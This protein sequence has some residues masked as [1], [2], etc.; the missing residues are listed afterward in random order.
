[1]D[2]VRGYAMVIFIG[3]TLAAIGI[4]I[5]SAARRTITATLLTYAVIL[6]FSVGTVVG[7]GIA[8]YVQ[9]RHRFDNS[10][11]IVAIDSRNPMWTLVLNPFLGMA[12]AI[13]GHDSG[14]ASRI[15]DPLDGLFSFLSSNSSNGLPQATAEVAPVRSGVVFGRSV[16]VR[17]GPFVAPLELHV[18]PSGK[19]SVVPRRL[20]TASQL[21]VPPPQFKP[22]APADPRPNGLF[23][24]SGP[25]AGVARVRHVPF[26]AWTVGWYILI[27]LGAFGIAVR[28]VRSPAR[29]LWSGRQGRRA[30]RRAAL[31]EA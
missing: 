24:P 14:G 13:Q 7:F 16:Q 25:P 15:G 18:L 21:P 1:M 3:I 28:R 27:S 31:G 26:W 10:G 30:R 2:V 29:K 9:V 23:A 11:E 17:T 6:L 22:I 20:R 5:S 19:V 4:A 12:S 8:K